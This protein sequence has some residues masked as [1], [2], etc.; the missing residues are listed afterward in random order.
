MLGENE[1]ISK[2]VVLL[3][4]GGIVLEGLVNLVPVVSPA[5]PKTHFVN[6]VCS[7]LRF[8]FLFLLLLPLSPFH[9]LI[10]PFSFCARGGEQ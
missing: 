9:S 4:F 8:A 5:A 3:E 10:H 7:F 6:S 2:N 1:D